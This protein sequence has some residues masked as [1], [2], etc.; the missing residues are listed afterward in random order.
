MMVTKLASPTLSRSMGLAIAAAALFSAHALGQATSAPA[1]LEQDASALLDSAMRAY[2]GGDYATSIDELSRILQARPSDQVARFL[3]AL[4]HGQLAVP[5]ERR[6]QL[7]RSQNQPEQAAAQIQIANQ[8]YAA[9]REDLATLIKGGLIDTTAM[10]HLLDAMVSLKLAGS[11]EG[12]YQA[13]LA[14]RAALLSQ[15]REALMAYLHPTPESGVTSPVGLD[16]VRAEYFLAVVTY[17]QAVRPSEQPDKPDET[18]DL[19]SLASAG[20]MMEALADPASPNY[21]GKLMPAA[22]PRELQNWLSYANLYLGLIR[23]RQGNDPNAK[24]DAGSNTRCYYEEAVRYFSEAWKLDTGQAYPSGA[25]ASAG[26]GLIPQ[27]VDRQVPALQEAMKSGPAYAEDFYLDLQA[28]VAYDTNVILLGQQTARPRGLGRKHDVRFESALALGYTLDLGKVN[29]DLDRW[30]V[31][32][33]GRTSANWHG[34]IEQYN[35][36]DYGG[37]VALQYRLLDSWQAGGHAQG[38]LYA[39]VQYDFDYFVLGNDGFLGVNRVSP[40]LTLYT[41]DQ[42]AITG[43]A[44]HY[45]DRDYHV[46]LPSRKFDRGG[47]YYAVDLSQSLDVVD[48]TRLYNHLGI[49][50]WGLKGDPVDPEQLSADNLTQDSTGYQRWLKP[51]AG[52]EYGMDSTKGSEFDAHRYMM[53]AGMIVPLPYGVELDFNSQWEWQDYYHRGSLVDYHRRGRNDFIQRYQVGLDRSFVLV[54]GVRTN[55]NTVKVDRLVMT[56]GLDA[57][58]V[59]DDSNVQDRLGE[60]VFS[61]DRAIWGINVAFRF[62]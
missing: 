3:R 29:A 11:V 32:I 23:T 25:E 56:L 37:S 30:T 41:M 18:A 45:E 2:A 20:S 57:V 13:R 46:S 43:L 59:D 9:M 24:C 50:P 61:Y 21:V 51:Y 53:T 1:S 49:E 8:E 33:L 55:R 7:A 15:A 31:G 40:Q 54:P 42:R 52:F 14:L 47:N 22:S 28:G 39:S 34:S 12:S 36:D 62:N 60:A 17:R 38:P 6:A 58:F 19:P 48:M 4:A 10:A 5:S 16:R 44:F 26:R 27:I 35:L